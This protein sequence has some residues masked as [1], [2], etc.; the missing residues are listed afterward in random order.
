VYNCCF[1][2]TQGEFSMIKFLSIVTVALATVLQPAVATASAESEIRILRQPGNGSVR[3]FLEAVVEVL[4]EE[5][6]RRG[7][8]NL[9]IKFADFQ[10]AADANVLMM[11]GDL[12]VMP[13]GINAYGTVLAKLDNKVKLLTGWSSFSYKLVCQDPNIR[14]VRDI[15]PDTKI[16]MKSS[17]S[18]EHYYIKSI[19][20]RDLGNVDALDKNVF[21]LP[22]PQIQQLMEA[23]DP[24]VGCAVPGTPIQDNLINGKFAHQVDLS[25]EKVT[26]GP[27]TGSYAMT[28][29]I[30]KNP[31]LAEAWVA[32]VKRAE[33]NFAADP[34]KY[35]QKFKDEDKLRDSVDTLYQNM[36]ASN[37]KFGAKPDTAVSY[38]DFM[39]D[40]GVIKTHKRQ[41]KDIAW[42]TDLF[43]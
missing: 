3:P 34:K 12:D 5:A 43:K 22:R 16:A 14:S 36:L 35:L 31:K 26:F 29:W 38:L 25:D 27:V 41:L 9:K 42:R 10:V 13:T 7:I 28:S 23:R 40:I 32:A 20:R 4:P 30:E 21:V 11:A 15:K 8:K 2:Q 19:A 1:N 18:A 17:M 39:I 6:A 33:K 24:S 37:L